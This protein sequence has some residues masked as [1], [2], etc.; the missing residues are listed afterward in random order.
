M[1]VVAEVACPL[2]RANTLVEN[3]L[4]GMKGSSSLPTWEV[5]AVSQ[6]AEGMEPLRTPRF[7]CCSVRA[8]CWVQATLL[9]SASLDVGERLRELCRHALLLLSTWS[10]GKVNDSCLFGRCG[11]VDRADRQVVGYVVVF[12]SESRGP[13][14]EL[15]LSRGGF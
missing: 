14:K 6:A 5:H 11:L 7:I 4:V 9:H 1:T 15:I 13:R 10:R 8:K 3:W 2:A 12:L